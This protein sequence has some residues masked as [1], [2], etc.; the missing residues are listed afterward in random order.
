M[1]ILANLAEDQKVQSP[2]TFTDAPFPLSRLIA[3]L[4]RIPDFRPADLRETHN[5]DDGPFL[6]AILI[7][8]GLIKAVGDNRFI[9]VGSDAPPN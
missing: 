1:R 2:G 4:A 9:L 7:H 5:N 3:R 8:I 6:T